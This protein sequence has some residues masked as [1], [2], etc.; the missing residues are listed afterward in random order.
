MNP[1][2]HQL[3]T[4]TFVTRHFKPEGTLSAQEKLLFYT[5]HQ[6]RRNIHTRTP[7]IIMHPTHVFPSIARSTMLA[8]P[9]VK[10]QFRLDE[11]FI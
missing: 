11:A 10:K 3:I 5:M 9:A 4:P 1:T 8:L 6:R 2:V 7:S